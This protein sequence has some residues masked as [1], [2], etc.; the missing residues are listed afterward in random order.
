MSVANNIL[1]PIDF[2]TYSEHALAYASALAK[3]LR[4]RVHL[5]N[6]IGIPALGVPEVPSVSLAT[7]IDQLTVENQAA[8]DKLAAPLREAGG[9]AMVRVGD[10]RDVIIQ[11]AEEVHADLIIIGTHGRRGLSRALLGSVAESV[12][13]SAP[14]PVLTVRAM[15]P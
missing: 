4:A 3:E 10:A 6:A 1:V 12:V 5:I 9:T 15:K 11:A 2:S 13:R 7:M 14:V 8:L